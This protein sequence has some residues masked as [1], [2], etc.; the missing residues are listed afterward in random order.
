MYWFIVYAFIILSASDAHNI[1]SW[2]PD[3]IKSKFLIR[4]ESY[5]QR[6]LYR[7]FQTGGTLPFSL[8]QNYLF[9]FKFVT[10]S[11]SVCCSCFE[12]LRFS[13]I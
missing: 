9:T 6:S 13:I 2:M 3:H 8:V 10:I 5:G 1:H 12:L 7:G 11:C 4:I